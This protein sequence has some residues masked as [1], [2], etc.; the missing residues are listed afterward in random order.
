MI[1]NLQ[2]L[3]IH[4]HLNQIHLPKETMSVVT[5]TRYVFKPVTRLSKSRGKI[6]VV[7]KVGHQFLQITT[8][9]KQ[10]VF[11][12]YRLST[13]V[14]DVFRLGDVDE[15]PTSIQTEDDSAFGLR[16]DNGRIV[17]YFTS[18]MVMDVL[19]AIRVA[20]AKYGKDNRLPKPYERLIR[21]QDVPGTLLNISL[22]N[23][24]SSDHVLR[25]ASY[26][27][28]GALCKA[29]QFSGSSRL[30]YMIGLSISCL[31]P[32]VALSARRGSC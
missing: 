21:P 12:G 31:P 19:Q 11:A 23:L 13:T 1:G 6:D 5:D 14:N 16:A 24:S 9:N 22:S 25:L 7:L 32:F 4:F 29:F 17:M 18:P 8:T 26:N 30:M 10:D 28:L 27:L 20:K 2:D 15:A 3:Q